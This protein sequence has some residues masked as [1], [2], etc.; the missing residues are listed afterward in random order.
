M[1]HRHIVHE[2]RHRY[3]VYHPRT[4]VFCGVEFERERSRE[5]L[6]GLL[7]MMRETV[8]TKIAEMG[9]KYDA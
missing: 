1:T 5:E 2:G 7:R 6:G 3:L 8:F 9:A 4:S